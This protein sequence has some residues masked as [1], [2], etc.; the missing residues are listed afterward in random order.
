MTRPL[1][2]FLCS[3]PL[4]IAHAH[5]V[6]KGHFAPED[7]CLLFCEPPANEA[8]IRPE[9]WR[10]VT[11]LAASCFA[12]GNRAR[13]IR[14]NLQVISERIDF[15]R[16]DSVHL[17]ISDLF[18]LMN[19]AA[20]AEMAK[21]CRR[22]GIDFSF[23]ILDEGA[24]LYTVGKLSWKRLIRCWGR[25]AYLTAHRLKTVVVRQSNAD[26]RHP[27]C[28]ALYCLHPQLI[29]PPDRV[30]VLP[31]DP[32]GL[33]EIYGD[34]FGELKLP[35]NSC[36][37]VSQPLYLSLGMQ[38]QAGLVSSCREMMARQGI[39]NFFYKPHHFDNPEWIRVLENQCK[40]TRIPRQEHFPVEVW[41]TRCNAD[42]IFGHFSSALLNLQ[43]YGYGGA[44]MACGLD[45]VR[46]AFSERRAYLEFRAALQKLRTVQ[47]VD[48][49]DVLRQ[50]AV[51]AAA[52]SLPEGAE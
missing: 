47:V 39:R 6:R 17:L 30:P 45:R 38:Y 48:P 29:T 1:N 44:V 52:K 15:A 43:V 3:S 51:S 11:I 36:V 20:V 16:H 23:S 12:N 40:F 8:L 22:A 7:E 25:S 34:A 37:Y 13:H 26:Y 14:Q 24:L 21:Q 50:R 10:E 2:I 49:Y 41:A 42:V 19:N 28:R 46:A 9:M 32:G 35:E 31:I 4:Q 27:L 5:L 33:H 18:W